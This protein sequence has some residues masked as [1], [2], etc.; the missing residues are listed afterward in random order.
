MH[1]NSEVDSVALEIFLGERRERAEDFYGAGDFP[2]ATTAQIW[3][4]I[5]TRVP[6][7]YISECAYI[8]GV[9]DRSV[10]SRRAGLDASLNKFR[11]ARRARTYVGLVRW[12]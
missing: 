4:F 1:A 10:F 3:I 2:Y 6:P 7:V 12:E 5:S 9:L 11:E 8:P